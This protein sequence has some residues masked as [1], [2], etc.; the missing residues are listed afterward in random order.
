[1]RFPQGYLCILL[2][3]LTGLPTVS[4]QG[5]D[6]RL[7][8]LN[9]NN[10]GANWE[11]NHDIIS[12]IREALPHVVALTET[13]QPL[14][15]PV[16][17]PHYSR[18]FGAY[19]VTS[20]YNVHYTPARDQPS[21]GVTLL[22]HKTLAM[23]KVPPTTSS[24][25]R[26]AAVDL[27][28]PTSDGHGKQVRVIGI[29]APARPIGNGRNLT[30]F[31]S[32]VQKLTRIDHDWVVLGDFNAYLNPWEEMGGSIRGYMAVL[33]SLRKAYRVFLANT[34]AIDA[35]HQNPH[36]NIWHDWTSRGHSSPDAKKILDRVAFARQMTCR[37]IITHRPIVA[38]T[39]HR[40]VEAHLITGALLP[41]TKHGLKNLAPRRLR[42]PRGWR[43]GQEY[44]SMNEHIKHS[45]NMEPPPRE[46]TSEKSYD[47]LL[48]YCHNT[49][50]AACKRVF[51]KKTPN[52]VNP[53]ITGTESPAC[54]RM[55]KSIQLIGRLIRA[56]ANGHMQRFLAR[57]PD[58]RKL[59]SRLPRPNNEPP[60]DMTNIPL[61]TSLASRR[62]IHALR[63]EKRR[64]L[65]ELRIL[66]RQAIPLS[67][68]MT[69]RRDFATALKGGRIKH[70]F[71]PHEVTNPPLLMKSTSA[72]NRT[73]TIY[74]STPNDRLDVF[75]DYYSNLYADTDLPDSQ[76]EWMT[77][78]AARHIQDKTGG[79]NTMEWPKLLGL[80]DL[81][82]ILGRG[83]PKPS[84][85][86]DGWEK[87]ALRH[88]E[89]DFLTLVMSLLNY[90]LQH[91]HFP[92]RLK[93]NY[94]APLYKNKGD[95]TDPANYRGV[96][97]ANLLFS[98]ASSHFAHT[99]QD[100]ARQR[101][102]VPASQMA[103]QPGVQPGDMTALLNQVHAAG[104]V[105]KQSYYAIK[106]DHTK[107]FDNLHAQA[108][109]DAVQFYGLPPSIG[110]F[111][112]ARTAN[113]TMR[114]KSQDGVGKRTI[115]TTGQT[116][117]GDAA[118]PIKYVMA[119]GMLT[120]WL[121]AG[122]PFAESDIPTVSS[123]NRRFNEY[124][125]VPA[126][127]EHPVE[128]LCVE[129]MDD[130][131]WF[132]K[133]WEKLQELVNWT[134]LFQSAYGVKTHWDSP[135]KTECFILGA[136]PADSDGPRGSNAIRIDTP[137]GRKDVPIT[138]H[139]TFLRTELHNPQATYDGILR[140]IEEFPI[141]TNKTLPIALLRRAVWGL[142]LPKIRPR[143]HQQP[144]TP[145]M[146][147]GIDDAISRKVLTALQI[148]YSKSRI[149]SLPV[150]CHGFGFPSVYTINGQIAINMMVRSLNHHL[151]PFRAIAGVCLTNWSCLD[152]AC[153]NP[154]ER[155]VTNRKKPVAHPHWDNTVPD[156]WHAALY[157]MKEVRFRVTSTDQS[158]YRD[159]A[160]THTANRISAAS[161]KAVPETAFSRLMD[162][163][164]AK[165]TL[166]GMQEQ[167][168][169]V[170]KDSRRPPDTARAAKVFLDWC[171]GLTLP[172]DFRETDGGVFYTPAARRANHAKLILDGFQDE[173]NDRLSVWATDGSHVGLGDHTSTTAAVVGPRTVSLKL[174]GQYSSS[175]HGELLASIAAQ[176][177]TSRLHGQ[178]GTQ[179]TVIFTDH[180]NSI[181]TITQARTGEEIPTS[182]QY[183]PAHEL[184]TWLYDTARHNVS[185]VR[186][187]KAH[188]GEGDEASKMNERA[189]T[190]A[191]AA[192]ESTATIKL[193]PITAWMRK[194]VVWAPDV[195]YI[196]DNWVSRFTA[197]MT[198]LLFKR[199]TVK[200][201][202]RL[203][204]PQGA[205]AT[206]TP[207][208]FYHKAPIGHTPKFQLILRLGQFYTGALRHRMYPAL[209]P[210]AA[211]S[212]C[213]HHTE[214][215]RHIFVD[216]PHFEEFRQEAV[217]KSRRFL[218]MRNGEGIADH[219]GAADWEAYAEK[220]LRG[221]GAEQTQYYYGIVPP[222][223]ESLSRYGERLAHHL[224]IILTSRI[225]GAYLRDTG[226]TYPINDGVERTVGQ[227]D[228]ENEKVE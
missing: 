143:L 166:K 56:E 168:R 88:T 9:V 34:S 1:M 197:Q 198:T 23:K 205:S 122:G 211:C 133:S 190:T 117:Q 51:P 142:L 132:A 60:R 159:H 103:T 44:A 196:P 29:Y 43:T 160:A 8:T 176:L 109:L 21:N 145:T 209:N 74:A 47:E 161:G 180:L 75:T 15:G 184:R 86:P 186:H 38:R 13:W 65:T 120:H 12:I 149:L 97:Y 17:L 35:W 221:S 201:Q 146:A 153:V 113:V 125:H 137:V 59:M 207:S 163:V 49:F 26:I 72:D 173:G 91:N 157:Y 16:N 102:L 71:E 98:L 2:I 31:W 187:V 22:V 85:G 148:R 106:R 169:K 46:P 7:L 213:G 140:I 156:E 116:K 144:L 61:G 14:R 206:D 20:Q 171:R 181:A 11:K 52:P 154:L 136:T 202:R 94:L 214:D 147:A 130:S 89:D 134:E 228:Q 212:R 104:I 172:T 188:T 112:M 178:R 77:S 80:G 107:G 78:T 79:E 48:D 90:T 28:I 3:M 224:A 204:D 32:Q 217:V 182:R 100:Y 115:S 129:A 193:P 200:Q 10:M 119:M 218:R 108:F 87:W 158:D 191:K 6:L 223:P 138:A 70:L 40:A 220:T 95:A 194:Y 164:G 82:K 150:Q 93:E 58:G 114:V 155:I 99:L 174:T 53:S 67:A 84:P 24:S 45:I 199:E 118:S 4:A 37:S 96:V 162:A 165:Y 216:C 30:D 110:S 123:Y 210:S 55:S 177:E 76:K 185:E 151:L 18:Q 135:N 57:E 208:Y 5:E 69:D 189:D 179:A 215:T 50:T 128:L 27:T 73:R 54:N 127:E 19:K 105:S 41:N 141:P 101:A 126:S 167:A 219:G 192:H 124:A 92:E 131:I 139:P 66:T 227:G 226:I 42:Q 175:L 152:N 170:V 121:T 33:D 225:A 62:T 81:R 222:A 111:E 195:G 36:V 39:N 83:N 63:T 68:A 203:Q 183:G 25:D 64:L